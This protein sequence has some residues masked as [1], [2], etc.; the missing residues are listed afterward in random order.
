MKKS[1]LL[2]IALLCIVTPSCSSNESTPAPIV[3]ED[4]DIIFKDDFDTF[5]SS[6]WTK[7]VHNSGWVNNELQAYDT[8]HISVGKDGDKSVLILT[9]ERKGDKIYSGRINSKNKKSFK[10]GTIQ[11]SIRLPKTN[12]G[13]WPAF[14]MMG[15]SNEGWPKCGE[16]DI[17]EMGERSGISSGNSETQINSAIHFGET[18][19]T[20]KQEYNLAIFPNS[21][22]DGKY[23]TYTL[24]WNDESITISVDGIKL[25]SYDINKSTEKHQYFSDN[26]HI[27][28]NLAVGGD[29]TGIKDIEKITALK[30]GQKVNMYV[31][32]VKISK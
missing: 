25:H 31:D 11:A 14:W 16:I 23:H 17:M 6:I 5:Q 21:L 12:A 29:F 30:D 8:D 4:E 20:H 19:A 1:L 26:F 3:E 2:F 10:Y 15:E 27:L 22:Q 18:P 7:E 24:E 13:L 9:A 28:F 32:W